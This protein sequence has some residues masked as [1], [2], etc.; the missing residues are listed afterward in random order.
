MG[1]ACRE[2]W[3]CRKKQYRRGPSSACIE[4][5]RPA[6]SPSPAARA[7]LIR[8]PLCTTSPACSQATRPA[9]R[10]VMG[11]SKHLDRHEGL[12]SHSTLHST[13]FTICLP[14]STWPQKIQ[15][16]TA[17]DV[18][19][20]RHHLLNASQGMSSSSPQLLCC[21]ASYVWPPCHA[22]LRALSPLPGRRPSCLQPLVTALVSSACCQV[23]SA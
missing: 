16:H 8:L 12:W 21:E 11:A 23:S 3:A 13:R 15:R 17:L 19:T 9:L 5:T 2:R 14:G 20:H 1:S 18:D 6:I 7:P 22:N 4:H 10:S